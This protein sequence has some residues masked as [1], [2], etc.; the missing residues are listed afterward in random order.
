LPRPPSD[1]PERILAAASA[2]LAAEG[3]TA[4]SYDRLAERSGLSKGGVLHHY[5]SRRELVAAL[6]GAT[7]EGLQGRIDARQARDGGSFARAWVAELLVDADHRAGAP[8]LAALTED[9]AL[10]A[11]LWARRGAWRKRLSAELG[12]ADAWLVQGA[13]ESLWLG[14]LLGAPAPDSAS[15]AVLRARLAELVGQGG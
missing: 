9:P 2:L 8:L 6:V 14:A 7:L 11:P 15:R 4:L 12:E 1:A 3:P 10:L 13:V 5:R